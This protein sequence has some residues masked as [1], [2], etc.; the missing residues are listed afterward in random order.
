[1]EKGTRHN[2][3]KYTSYATMIKGSRTIGHRKGK[4]ISGEHVLIPED[5]VQLE[6]SMLR[7]Y[8]QLFDFKFPMEKVD[9]FDY[10]LPG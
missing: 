1:M 5:V 8:E 6:V 3:K 4:L 9:Y 2:S 7:D 10:F